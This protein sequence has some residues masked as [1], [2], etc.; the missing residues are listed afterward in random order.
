M[1]RKRVLLKHLQ[2]ALDPVLRAYRLARPH[3]LLDSR[4][5]H[6]P[7]IIRLSV[8]SLSLTE[9]RTVGQTPNSRPVRLALSAY[10]ASVSPCSS[11]SR[12]RSSCSCRRRANSPFETS[13]SGQNL[14]CTVRAGPV[15]SSHPYPSK[16]ST[17][18]YRKPCSFIHS[19]EKILLR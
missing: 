2:L 17:F 6:N 7:E 4:D 9:S 5:C 16:R 3:I 12:A 11:S 14:A 8:I 1:H 15:D 19:S 13:R 10:S 18:Y